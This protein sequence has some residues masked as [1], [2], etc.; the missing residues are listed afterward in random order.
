MSSAF[1]DQPEPRE[2]G[3]YG[4]ILLAFM[5]LGML[6]GILF[7]SW[8]GTPRI[9]PAVGQPLAKLELTPIA[10]AEK[11]FQRK[12]S[13]AKLPCSIFGAPGAVLPHRVP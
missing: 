2:R 1:S 10:F 3:P 9:V 8:L 5:G 11:N 6:A 13:G 7:L 12:I 4:L